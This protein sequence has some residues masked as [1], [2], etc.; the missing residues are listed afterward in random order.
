[1]LLGLPWLR[2]IDTKLFIQKKEIHIRD[3]KKKEAVSQI[4][5]S[6]TPSE[7]TCF[8]SSDK[9]RANINKTSEKDIEHEDKVSS[10]EES[11]DKSS[12]KGF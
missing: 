2:S 12:D 4:S 9:G 11:D 1:M 7:D 8:Q 3:S 5:Y 10:E 6:I